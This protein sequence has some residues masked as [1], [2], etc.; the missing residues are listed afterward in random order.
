MLL[1]NF[2]LTTKEMHKRQHYFLVYFNGPAISLI[3]RTFFLKN[4]FSIL[5]GAISSISVL[6]LTTFSLQFYARYFEEKL[7][8][9]AKLDYTKIFWYLFVCILPVPVPITHCCCGNYTVNCVPIQF[10]DF[11]NIL[12]FHQIAKDSICRKFFSS[13]WG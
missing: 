11:S 4:V 12:W 1:K 13:W 2:V 8:N 7:R 9:Q 3:F 5:S 10:L 6:S